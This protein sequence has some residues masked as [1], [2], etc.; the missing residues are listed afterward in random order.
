MKKSTR[1]LV[2]ANSTLALAVLQACGGGSG[3]D[4]N[5]DAAEG[6][7]LKAATP[8]DASDIPL[9]T[10]SSQAPTLRGLADNLVIDRGKSADVPVEVASQAALRG[11]FSKV[12]GSDAAFQLDLSGIEATA[13]EKSDVLIT[14]LQF[15]VRE[16][17][18]GSE[19]C[20]DL[21]AQDI[22]AL[23]SAPE[24]ICV[25]V[26]SPLIPNQ[27]PVLGNIATINAALGQ[28]VSLVASASDPDGDDITY[29]WRQLRGPE[30]ALEAPASFQTQF[31][32]PNV[33]GTTELLFQVVAT[34][35]VGAF[36]TAT[37]VVVVEVANRSPIVNAGSDREVNS[38]DLVRLSGSA[39]DI[40]NDPL[41]IEWSQ[42]G[43]VPV[44]LD[45][46]FGLTP[47]FIAPPRGRSGLCQHRTAGC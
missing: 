43:G 27:S 24:P 47:Q 21:Q 46:P 32:V 19:F 30:V 31:I 37:A 11:L 16:D 8:I 39:T 33:F 18:A 26:A 2:K 36:S 25:N 7:F 17:Y 4:G 44:S 6:L 13:R 9:E 20:I 14:N 35:S 15:S 38:G 29:E 34:D 22:R 12:I 41:T 40:D 28:R 23:T 5:L 45:N 42:I 10:P 1:V 3:A